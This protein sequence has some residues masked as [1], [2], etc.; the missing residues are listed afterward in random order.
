MMD[1]PISTI[2]TGGQYGDGLVVWVVWEQSL[3]YG[4]ISQSAQIYTIPTIQLEQ[5]TELQV[6]ILRIALKRVLPYGVLRSVSI[7]DLESTVLELYT[8]N[9]YNLCCKVQN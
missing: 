1:P 9:L 4:V 5:H 7:I 8:N 3:L 2:V 6:R